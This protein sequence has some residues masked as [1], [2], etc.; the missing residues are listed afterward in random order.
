M[1]KTGKYHRT[2]YFK[3]YILNFKKSEKLK[4]VKFHKTPPFK[5]LYMKFGKK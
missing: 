1:F 4:T 3:V 5:E 2:P